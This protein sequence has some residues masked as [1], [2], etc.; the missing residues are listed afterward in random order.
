M[1]KDKKI[2]IQKPV[3]TGSGA[4]KVTTWVDLG[5]AAD[6]DPP[7]YLWAY[8]RHMSQKEMLLSMA[9]TYI[10]DVLFTINWR[11]DVYAGQRVVYGGMNYQIV[12]VDN[13]EGNKTDLK[14]YGKLI[15]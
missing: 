11:A 8:F 10:S 7:R 14:V 1:L 3:T 4:S 15:P 5:N 12:N 9:Q 2:R 6:T 13:F